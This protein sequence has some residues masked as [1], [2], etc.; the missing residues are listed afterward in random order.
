MPD[1]NTKDIF[2]DTANNYDWNDNVENNINR[3]MRRA[4]E[5]LKKNTAVIER[6]KAEIEARAK[7][8]EYER[9][10]LEKK[11]RLEKLKARYNRLAKS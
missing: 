2:L 11:N 1:D 7:N 9:V 5:R 4:E 6:K 3:L 10:Q 8:D